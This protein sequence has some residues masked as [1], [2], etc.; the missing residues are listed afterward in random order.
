MARHNKLHE[1]YLFCPYCKQKQRDAVRRFQKSDN[2]YSIHYNCEGCEKTI[3][4]IENI[5]GIYRTG[6]I[7]L[8]TKKEKD[9]IS[10]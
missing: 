5:N 2:S 9:A 1:D 6:K 3:R 4:I 10:K 7:T 8:K